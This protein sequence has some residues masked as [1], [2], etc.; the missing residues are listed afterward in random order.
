MVWWTE[1]LRATPEIAGLTVLNVTGM[2]VTY[3][4]PCPTG[5]QSPHRRIR[6]Y[7]RRAAAVN[8]NG[9]FR[10]LAPEL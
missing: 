4:G 2:A 9:R 7:G 8:R 6:Q 3:A 1:V 5:C 10:H